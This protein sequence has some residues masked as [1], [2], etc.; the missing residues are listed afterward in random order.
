MQIPDLKQ[1]DKLIALC[2]KRGVKTVKIDNMELTLSDEVPE[3]PKTRKSATTAPQTIPDTFQ[4]DA[5]SD[6]EMLFWSVAQSKAKEEE[7]A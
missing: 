7:P 4:S 3:P 1:L 5:I 2:R 6:E